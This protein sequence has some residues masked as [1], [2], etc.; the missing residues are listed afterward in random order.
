M[1]HEANL[2]ATLSVAFVLAFAG[3][4]LADR[5]RLPPLVGYLM[6][7]VLVGPFTPGFV[8]DGELA[9]ELAEMGVILLMFGVG[10]HFSASD[11]MAVKGVAI[12][13][14]IVQILAA[15]GLGVGLASLWDWGLGAGLVL[16][17][18]LSVASTVVLLKA[19]EERNLLNTS[20]GRIAVGWLIVED[21]AMVVALVLLPAAAELLGGHPLAGADGHGGGGSDGSVLLTLALTLGKVAIFA[22]L[23][24]ALGPRVV[25]WLLAQVARTGSRELFTLA[26]LAVALG[27]AYGSAKLFGVS[28]ALGAFF[29]GVVL[30]ESRFSHKAAADSMPLQDAF[31]VIFFVSVGMLFDPSILVREP[32]AVAAVL[33]TIIVGKSI[34]AFGIVRM[35][36]Y[37]TSTGLM[38]SASLAQIGEFS[39]ILVGLGMAL[40]LLPPEGRDLVLAGALLS[41][42]LNPLSFY[43]VG[44]IEKG[45]KARAPAGDV[46]GL[47]KFLALE[48]EIERARQRMEEKERTHS[49]QVQGLEQTFPVLSRLDREELER[50]LLMFRPRTAAPGEKVIRRGDRADGMYFI[51][52]GSVSVQAAGH[53]I[54]L[55]RGTFF[56]EMALLSGRRRSAD[57]TALDYC[58][59]LMLDRRDFHQFMA[60]HP[61][62]RAAVMELANQRRKMNSGTT[63]AIATN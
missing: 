46:Q 52:S 30:S 42:T 44:R 9:T 48:Q 3:G 36:G 37:P 8:A 60:R 32:V 34:F 19:L 17:L 11:M 7:G 21:L 10:L 49:L 23:A 24:L 38:V 2:I 25:P 4:M 39:F 53:T 54:K 12:P 27:I 15:T 50:L 62:L 58:E 18:S 47:P 35:L 59:F 20:N 31:S 51:S 55:E 63:T 1:P 43:I 14:A 56:G 61:G 28:F 45:M 33:L 6:A 26:V 5:L 40:G 13:G 41:I 57:V 16:G 29:A 22:T